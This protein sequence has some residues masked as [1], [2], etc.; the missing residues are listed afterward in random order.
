M[1]DAEEGQGDGEQRDPGHP[2]AGKGLSR[3]QQSGLEMVKHIM[4]SLDE[5]DGLNEVYTFRFFFV[6]SDLYFPLFTLLCL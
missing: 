3:E 4:L 6:S 2:G 1:E 5:E